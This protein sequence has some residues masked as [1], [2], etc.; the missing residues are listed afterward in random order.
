[1]ISDACG[2][3]ENMTFTKPSHKV[4]M[5][6]ESHRFFFPISSKLEACNFLSQ[7]AGSSLSSSDSQPWSL[8]GFFGTKYANKLQFEKSKPCSVCTHWPSHDLCSHFTHCWSSP[9]RSSTFN[10]R[11]AEQCLAGHALL[12]ELVLCVA[13]GAPAALRWHLPLIFRSKKADIFYSSVF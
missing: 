7:G 8:G 9:A 10:E 11:V 4:I 1:M 6:L 2:R 5:H 13:A 3:D 12:P